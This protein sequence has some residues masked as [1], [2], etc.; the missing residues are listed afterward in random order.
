MF[1]RFIKKKCAVRAILEYSLQKCVISQRLAI[2]SF[3][4]NWHFPLSNLVIPKLTKLWLKFDVKQ[5]KFGSVLRVEIGPA[6]ERKN[7]RDIKLMIS[8][9]VLSK[10]NL[11]NLL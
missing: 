11:S 7:I 2:T 8:P 4:S 1:K 10:N 3:G 6:K 9:D 5:K